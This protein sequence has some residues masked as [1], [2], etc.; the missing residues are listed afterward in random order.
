MY[1]TKRDGYTTIRTFYVQVIPALYDL[2]D[3]ANIV[4]V[5]QDQY[6][7]S[8]VVIN[9]NIHIVVTLNVTPLS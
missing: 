4:Q 5:V 3:S 9:S 1:S 8:V 6:S 2:K 7:S